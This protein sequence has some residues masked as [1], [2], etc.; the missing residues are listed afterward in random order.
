MRFSCQPGCTKCCTRRGWVYLTEEDLARAAEYLQM[1]TAA[2]ERAYVVRFRHLL[3][4]RKPPRSKNG[5]HFLEA[6]GCAIHPVKPTQCRTYPFWPSLV[7]SRYAWKLEAL[8][9]PGI[10]K[11]GLVTIQAAREIAAELPKA[12]P[13]LNDF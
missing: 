9:C 5:C 6:G 3:R 1:S 10:G 7:N 2:F 11:G 8:F 4:L 12:Y 13:N